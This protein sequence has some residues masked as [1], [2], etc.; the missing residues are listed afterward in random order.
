MKMWITIAVLTVLF[1]TTLCLPAPSNETI[2]ADIDLLTPQ[3]TPPDNT[4][5]SSSSSKTIEIVFGGDVSFDQ[6]IRNGNGSNCEYGPIMG[7]VK[8]YLS[9]ADYSVVSLV[10]PFVS[11]EI[12]ESG[13]MDGKPVNV[14]AWPESVVALTSGGVDAVAVANDHLLDYGPEG[15]AFTN[16]LLQDNKI[17]LVGVSKGNDSTTSRQKPLLVDMKGI[18]VGMLS[19]CLLPGLCP[20]YSNSSALGYA[21]YNDALA[22]TE[23]EELQQKVDV[24]VVYMYWGGF[25]EALPQESDREVAMFLADLGVNFIVGNYHHITQTHEYFNQTLVKYSLGN[26]VHHAHL[27]K[28]TYLPGSPDSEVVFKEIASKGGRGPGAY[29][30]LFAVKFDK[31]GVVDAKLLP[32]RVK[33]DK[34]TGCL[35]PTPT[36]D[37]WIQ[38]CGPEDVNCMGPPETPKE[39]ISPPVDSLFYTKPPKVE[40]SGN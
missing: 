14:K 32:V 13:A 11:R 10:S 25:Y 9:S 22:R 28:P 19:Y 5:A 35:Y 20:D 26:L 39:P 30:E 6:P 34:D 15:V 12:A 31:Q 1:E 4:N 29:S 8:K 7:N 24:V 33:V 36:R 3:P 2:L 38:V 21:I 18:K 16:N 17:G 27:Y 40:E 37:T 23:I